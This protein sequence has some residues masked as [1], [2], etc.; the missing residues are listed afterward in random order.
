[1]VR[2]I[3]KYLREVDTV[4]R[5]FC[6]RSADHSKSSQL[7]LLLLFIFIEVLLLTDIIE[8]LQKLGHIRVSCP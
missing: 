6:L 8:Q 3:L 7:N 2:L 4:K 1:M 5:V